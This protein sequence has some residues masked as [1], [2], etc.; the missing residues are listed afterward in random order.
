MTPLQR[1][2]AKVLAAVERYYEGGAARPAPA[3]HGG[4][5]RRD[6]EARGRQPRAGEETTCQPKVYHPPV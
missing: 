5:C 2:Q 4:G 3:N 6:D 1:W